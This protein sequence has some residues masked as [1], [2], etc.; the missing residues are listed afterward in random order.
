[1]GDDRSPAPDG[2]VLECNQAVATRL[3]KRRQEVIGLVI[4]DQFPPDVAQRRRSRIDRVFKTG[5]L[6]IYEDVEGETTFRNSLRP[7]KD[8]QGNVWAVALFASDIT[9]ARQAEQ[10]L[11]QSEDR[12]ALALKSSDMG[13]FEWD[14][15]RDVRWWDDTTYRLLGVNRGTFSGLSAEFFALVHPDDHDALRESLHRAADGASCEFA[16]RVIWPDGS[17]HHI[18]SRGRV[19]RDNSDKPV[20]MTGVCWD[21]T[22]AMA[23]ETEREAL[24]AVLKLIHVATDKRELIRSV[25]DFLH[26]WSGC[27]AVGVRLRDGDDFPYYETRGFSRE[28]V[29]AES[30]LCSEK[31]SD[32]PPGGCCVSPALDCMCGNILCGRFDPS[33]PFFT[34]YGSFWTNCTTDLLASTTQAD[35]QA[36]TRNRCNGEGY[37]SVALIPLRGRYDVRPAPV[38]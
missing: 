18:R 38:Q 23:I 2:R 36:R 10:A 12:L 4:Y 28:F 34:P 14:I 35:R 8:D 6:L 3:G 11:G 13:V 31:T 26:R 22:A 30:R 27:Q 21:V 1:M 5:Q 29:Q 19:H 9:A 15:V 16:Y 17:V 37:E 25:T 7:L 24:L 32:L 20:R 33:K